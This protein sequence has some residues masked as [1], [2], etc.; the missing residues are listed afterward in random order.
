MTQVLAHCHWQPDRAAHPTLLILHGLE[1]SSD[2]H[3]MKGIAEKA[4][5]RGFNA[6]RLN[7]R[8]C[9]ETDHLSEGLYHSG[10]AEDP[11]GV[12]RQLAETDG[13]RRFAVAG[14]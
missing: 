5:M 3:Y 8:N 6:L 12:L 2:A 9:G 7:Q 13:L 10:L 4:F 11:R 1:G 14:Y